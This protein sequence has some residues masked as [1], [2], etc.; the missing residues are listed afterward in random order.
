MFSNSALQGISFDGLMDPNANG[1]GLSNNAMLQSQQQGGQSQ[2]LQGVNSNSNGNLLQQSFQQQGLQGMGANN[3]MFQQGMPAGVGNN[4]MFPSAQDGNLLSGNSASDL[5]NLSNTN[6]M[7]GNNNQVMSSP[8]PINPKL[9]MVSLLQRD[10]SFNSQVPSVTGT[11]ASASS[12]HSNLSLSNRGMGI[13][14]F[15]N[16]TF[17]SNVPAPAAVENAQMAAMFGN[18]SSGEV[19]MDPRQQLQQQQQGMMGAGLWSER[20]S[21]LLGNMVCAPNAKKTKRVKKKAPKDKPKRPLSAYNIYF[22]EERARLLA[23]DMEE[24]QFGPEHRTASGKIKFENLAKIISARWGSLE[25]NEMDY[26]KEKADE[27]MQR[28]RSQM[29]VYKKKHEQEAA[30]SQ[31]GGTGE[32]NDD[33]QPTA[34]RQKV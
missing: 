26:Y 19:I 21:S 2:A 10:P 17:P 32:T 8:M 4:M 23:K 25:S 5:M 22:K 13:Q 20:A 15:T 11:N 3:F 29:E 24:S 7:F 14:G 1:A 9:R 31:T 12:F 28:Y 6:S 30:A 18:N 34:K 33:D 27:D 16:A